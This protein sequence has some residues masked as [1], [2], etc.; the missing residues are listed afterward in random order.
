MN[1][2]RID[3]KNSFFH[4]SRN[5]LCLNN[6]NYKEWLENKILPNTRLIIEPRI[7]GYAL[8]LS[9]QAGVLVRA[10]TKKEKIKLR[11]SKQ[12]KLFLSDYL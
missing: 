9:Y 1:L 10:I 12:L 6:T 5:L 8:A 11:Q 7:D 2:K 3:P 4:K